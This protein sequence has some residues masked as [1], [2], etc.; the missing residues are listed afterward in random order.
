MRT[1]CCF[2]VSDPRNRLRLSLLWLANRRKKVHIASARNRHHQGQD[3]TWRSTSAIISCQCR[4]NE[5]TA[6]HTREETASERVTPA[7]RIQPVCLPSKASSA[8]ALIRACEWPAG[9][10]SP[11]SCHVA[12]SLLRKPAIKVC[13]T[14]FWRSAGVVLT[15]PKV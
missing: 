14:T 8:R 12:A 7:H 6:H 3:T 2:N 11:V 5:S 10:E 1:P 9:S 4:Q 13:S 15:T